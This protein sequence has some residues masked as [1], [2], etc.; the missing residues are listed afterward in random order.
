MK[1]ELSL[2][3]ATGDRPQKPKAL[4]K[5]WSTEYQVIRTDLKQLDDNTDWRDLRFIMFDDLL[6]VRA[7]LCP[8]A[9]TR[10]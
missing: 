10:C 7:F 9:C 5:G 3:Q 4:N 6:C 2:W 1:Y 8:P